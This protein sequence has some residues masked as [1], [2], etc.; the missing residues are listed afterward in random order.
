MLFDEEKEILAKFL[1]DNNLQLKHLLNTHLHFDHVLGVPFIHEKYSQGTK[2]HKGD[3]F[4]LERVKEQAAMFG[5]PFDADEIP[6]DK[7]IDENDVIEF[8]NTK[9]KIFH[10]PGHSPGSL[11]FYSE[12]DKCMF[13]GDV[14]FSGSIGRTD[15]PGGDYRELITGIREK[16]LT[17]P[18]DVVVYSGHGPKTTVGKEKKSNPFL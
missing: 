16:L 10:V 7:F 6:V 13:A 15:L 12:P 11:V 2:A 1:T 14:L 18:E 8:G 4:L 9:L 5:V 17:L 3:L